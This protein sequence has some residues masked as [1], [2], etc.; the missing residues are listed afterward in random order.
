MISKSQH[1]RIDKDLRLG[2]LRKLCSSLQDAI[3][4][5]DSEL[6]A[7]LYDELSLVY[8]EVFA[9]EDYSFGFLKEYCLA[10]IVCLQFKAYNNMSGTALEEGKKTIE[11]I[12]F[13]ISNSDYTKEEKEQLK[14]FKTQIKNILA[15][16]KAHRN[17]VVPRLDCRC[18]LCRVRPA[19]KT[20][21]HM[22]PNFLAHPTFSWDG[23]GK[24]GH[25]ALNHDFLNTP[26]RNC[27]FYGNEVPGWR[28]ALGEGKKDAEEVTDEDI[29]KNINQIEYDNEFCSVCEKRFGVLETAYAQF[30]SGQTKKIDARVAYLFW[31]SV[32]WRMSMGSMSIFMDI[33]DE[34]SLRRLLNDNIL[35]TI[36]EIA[37]NDS[38]LG[39]WKYAMFRAE[40]LKEGDKGILGYRK[41]CSPYVV[42]YNDLVMVF[43]HDNPTEEELE[44]G[45]INVVRELLNDWHSPE[46]TIKVDRRW[47]WNVRDW[48]V[49]TSYDFFDPVREKVLI[50]IRERERSMDKVVSAYKKEQAIKAVR[51][52]EPPRE[53]QCVL[54]KFPRISIAWE[55]MKEADAKGELYDP[56]SDD[57]I[58]LTEA[59]FHKYYRDLANFAKHNSEV[60]VSEFPFYEKARGFV[61]DDS[62]WKA[63]EDYEPTDPEYLASLS[64]ALSGLNLRKMK[65]ILGEENEPYVSPYPRIG[66]NDLC[67]CG[68]GKKFKKCCGR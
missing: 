4:A 56:L 38:D 3:A 13:L 54:H 61:S 9:A 55:R 64:D 45:P 26:D 62:Q 44:I 41:E 67:P 68:S 20:G 50:D 6:M 2:E 39:V 15:P 23:K 30:Y 29:E 12:D 60:R 36:D 7:N 40:G 53:K 49:E 11:M 66:R 42:M 35:N 46:K 8:T 34:L 37:R 14:N 21:S 48:I 52:T 51:L 59:D 47:F 32:L 10:T 22:V 16:L 5:R 28:F 57:D 65:R 18:T 31:L 27:Q 24:R 25:E 58:F 17:L 43:Y 19:N 1:S 33:E 63:D